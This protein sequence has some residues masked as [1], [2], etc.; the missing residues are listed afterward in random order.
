MSKGTNRTSPKQGRTQHKARPRTKYVRF[1]DTVAKRKRR[2][3]DKS[4]ESYDVRRKRAEATDDPRS[5][6]EKR[7][8]RRRAAHEK[9]VQ[10][11]RSP[12]SRK[13]TS[14]TLLLRVFNRHQRNKN[15]R[16]LER[17]EKE[18]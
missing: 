9:V 12:G 2:N 18:R 11:S 13:P 15:E 17:W 4:N 6:A 16:V 8:E 14:N 10:E 5:A 7:R 1:W 3:L